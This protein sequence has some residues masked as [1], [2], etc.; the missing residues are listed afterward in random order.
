MSKSKESGQKTFADNSKGWYKAVN[1]AQY[2]M[3]KYNDI[4]EFPNEFIP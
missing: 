4:E 1:E 3:K 2:Y